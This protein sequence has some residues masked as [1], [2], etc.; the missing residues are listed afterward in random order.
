MRESEEKNSMYLGKSI[1]EVFGMSDISLPRNMPS[2][3]PVNLMMPTLTWVSINDVANK[4]GGYQPARISY[5]P[6]LMT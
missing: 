6:G 4:A 5:Y 3:Q 2:K 1:T